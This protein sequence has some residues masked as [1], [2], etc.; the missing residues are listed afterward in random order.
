MRFYGFAHDEIT[1]GDGGMLALDVDPKLAWALAHRDR[2]PVDLN[3]APHRPALRA[4][5][6]RGSPQVRA[7][8]PEHADDR[9]R[10]CH[11]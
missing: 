3:R 1:A 7:R 4:A 6:P 5:T 9:G 8:R 10:R 2:F 11:L